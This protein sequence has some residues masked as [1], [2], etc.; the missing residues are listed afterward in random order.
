MTNIKTN[1]LVIV[2]SSTKAKLISKYLNQSN[3]LSELGGFEVIACFGHIRDLQQN[4]LGIDTNTFECFY[5]N[6]KSKSKIIS[7]LKHKI[8]QSEKIWL[9]ADNDREG[10]GIAWHLKE[11]FKINNYARIVFNE[12]TKY[13]II[14]AIKNPRLIDD[15]LVNSQQCRR[16]LDRLMG[17]KITKTLWDNIN[18]KAKIS[19]GR[20]QSP[21]LQLIIEK[22][23]EINSFDNRCYW[24]INGT[25]KKP[26]GEL[27]LHKQ[28][29]VFRS[30][31]QNEVIKLL[32][33][34]KNKTP[35][36]KLD[37]CEKKN[38]NEYAPAPFITSTLQQVC[39][40]KLGFSV[41]KTMKVAQQLYEMGLITYM[42]TDCCSI[43]NLIKPSIKSYIEDTYLINDYE[44][45]TYRFNAKK[46]K[47][48]QE[49]HEAIR[50]T[51]IVQNPP[52]KTLNKDQEKMYLLIFK[53][54]IASMMKPA[55]YE[56]LKIRL[57]CNLLEKDECF[58]GTN[59]FLQ[60]EGWLKVYDKVKCET[61][62][63]NL[64]ET[65][66]NTSKI[67]VIKI[68]GINHWLSPPLRYSEASLVNKLE[69]CGIGRPS[70][71]ASIIEKLFE[72]QFIK[73]TFIDGYEKEI[74]NFELKF[75]DKEIKSQNK[76]I[77]V[78]KEKNK[79]VPLEIGTLVNTFVT[80]NFNDVVNIEFTKDMETKLDD[81]AVG[82][83]NKTEY[84]KTFYECFK[85]SIE[86][87]NKSTPI[88]IPSSLNNNNDKCFDVDE[89][90]DQLTLRGINSKSVLI[91]ARNA[92]YGPVIEI[93]NGNDKKYI[94]LKAYFE[95]NKQTIEELTVTDV[96]LLLN[97]PYKVEKNEIQYQFLY[98]RYGFYIKTNTGKNYNINRYIDY[99]KQ[100]K[101]DNIVNKLTSH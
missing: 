61:N 7:N 18:I 40:T 63:N 101:F 1:N 14:N 65:Y 75:K 56:E 8:N 77:I 29:E 60:Y 38:I 9:A 4:G 90:K 79:L 72:K 97:I 10:E 32:T 53:R 43:S 100:L 11:A 36:F 41:Q 48:A 82:N 94:D 23:S 96:K 20:V 86:N 99:L 88:S 91:K 15:D 81:I 49:A 89:L 69:K 5:E 27:V 51:H 44:D 66:K 24:N 67:N 83:V 19:T 50:P 74:C 17:Y 12:I 13:A 87:S 76:T 42:R 45:N 73:N 31:S 37:P 46:V 33:D 2:E 30:Y 16:I 80:T 64:L 21:T 6:I 95:I 54:T 98:G 85:K 59:K 26:I 55:I 57:F 35:I 62:V 52:N 47:N 68:S 84:L 22:E 92:K 3:E 34:F 78:G 25:F 39:N 71:Y 93:V 58:V 28:N 70:T